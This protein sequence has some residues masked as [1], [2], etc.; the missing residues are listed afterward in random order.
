MKLQSA[1]YLEVQDETVSAWGPKEMNYEKLN[2]TARS[3][4]Y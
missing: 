2:L 1:S 4:K 3:R